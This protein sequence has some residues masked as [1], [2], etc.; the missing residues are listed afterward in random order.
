[1]H[2][3][4]G[5]GQLDA[6]PASRPEDRRAFIEE[7][8]G[9][10]KHRKRKEKALRKLDAMQA[11]LARLTDLTDR[12]A[13][14]AQAA[15]PAG[16]GGP[17]GR[18]PSR[19]T[20]A[21]PGC[22]CWPTTWSPGG[23]SSTTP[24]RPRRRLRAR[25]RRLVEAQLE[26]GTRRAG[27]AR[28]PRSAW[29]RAE[30][31]GGRPAD[32]VPPV[33]LAER[34]SATVRIA[35]ERAPASGHRAR[36]RAPAA[37]PTSWRPRPRRCASR[38]TSCAR[39]WPSHQAPGSARATSCTP[40]ANAALAAGRAGASWRPPG[41]IADRREGLARLTGQVNTLRTRVRRGRRRDRAAGRWRHRRGRGESP[42]GAGRVRDGAG[43]SSAKLDAGEA[44]LDDRHDRAVA[45]ADALAD[46][47]GA[48]EL[49]RGRAVARRERAG[50]AR[51]S[52][53][54]EAL[55]G[56]PAPASDGAGVC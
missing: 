53:R 8:A 37:T 13:P 25:A 7:A 41:P 5:Q 55:V 27:R 38:S 34:V 49:H 1:M 4:V 36:G 46:A 39:N 45:S 19:P 52:A 42:A 24:S 10:L 21:T 54:I 20:C 11:N 33:G 2:V 14:P 35:T 56:R 31:R 17:P 44:G 51:G 16:R 43:T 28:G 47:A 23:P 40:A 15:R 48:P 29:T 32:L 26:A 12:A 9:V 22:G 3:I 6:D 18:R 30:L 50:G